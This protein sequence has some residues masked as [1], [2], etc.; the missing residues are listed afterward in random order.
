MSREARHSESRML[1]ELFAQ[2]LIFGFHWG[3]NA[4]GITSSHRGNPLGRGKAWRRTSRIREANG[5]KALFV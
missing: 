2:F 3:S 4:F 1:S 5:D